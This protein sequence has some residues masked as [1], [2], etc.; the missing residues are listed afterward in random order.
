MCVC[1]VEFS[2]RNP[3]IA[4]PV[5]SFFLFSQCK[6]LATACSGSGAPSLALEALVG[7][8]NFSEVVSSESHA[9]RLHHVMTHG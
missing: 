7:H 4:M 5:F 1:S 3:S 9:S 8:Y 6:V 2:A